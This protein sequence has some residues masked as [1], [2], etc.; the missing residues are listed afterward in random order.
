MHA[1]SESETMHAQDS[2]A[3]RS[4]Q[5]HQSI[6]FMGILIKAHIKKKCHQHGD[7]GLVPQRKV[8]KE[9]QKKKKKKEPAV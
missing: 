3:P 4:Q 6:A 9:G 2:L 7:V 1:W 5:S 8:S